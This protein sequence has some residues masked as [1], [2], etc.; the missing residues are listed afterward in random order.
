MTGPAPTGGGGRFP[1]TRWSAVEG[2]RSAEPEERRRSLEALVTAY[3][4]PVYKYVRIRWNRS[5]EEA[6]DLTQGFFLRALEKDFFRSYDPGK[7]RF[8][9]FL[10]VCLDGFLANEDRSG[11]RLKRGGGETFVP[12][13][14]ATLERELA[15]PGGS[16]GGESPERFF[17]QEWIRGLF[18]LAVESLRGECGAAGKEVHFRL[19]ERY[20]L[21]EDEEHRPTYREL[22][23][24][25]RIATTDVTNYLA[26][27]RREFRRLLLDALRETTAGEEEFRRE[28]RLLLG[29]RG[30]GP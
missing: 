8:R 7:A 29:V 30:E 6:E 14:F 12:L 25:H 17:E 18:T 11:K 2:A 3:W 4:R 15:A 16:A 5:P 9:T 28:A 27:A 26:F 10:R 24:E 22:A 20:D 1:T 23:E 13:D 19:F 21:A